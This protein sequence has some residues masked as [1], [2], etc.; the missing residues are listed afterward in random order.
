M[1]QNGC[2]DKRPGA[3]AARRSPGA[4]T[5]AQEF[6]T[7]RLSLS[8]GDEVVAVLSH[9]PYRLIELPRVGFKIADGIAR[10]LGIELDH[11]QR[12]QA[13]L[14]FVLEEAESDGNTFVPLAELWHRAGRLLGV[15]ELDP[16]ESALRALV[17]S[18][19]VLV[20]GERVYRAELWEME[21][22]LAA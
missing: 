19:E 15:G 17:A 6:A 2:T 5:A 13:G 20:E 7:S 22:R 9:E 21:R 18:A 14:R 3:E 1:R 8:Y 11:P 16:L 12:L 4:L 10:S